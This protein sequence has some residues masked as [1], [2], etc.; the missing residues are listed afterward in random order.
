MARLTLIASPSPC[1][2]P[3]LAFDNIAVR[4]G[5]AAGETRYSVS[6]APFDN[7][8][9]TTLADQAPLETVRARVPI[10]SGVWSP[11][12]PAGIQYAVAAVAT[13]TPQFSHWATPVRVTIR[14][15]GAMID[16][17]GIERPTA[18]PARSTTATTP[19]S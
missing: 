6:W 18:F 13:L 5:L 15:R 11:P 17:V 7:R 14:N 8:T 4:L 10:P 12:D 1:P 16:V 2:A 19:A 3:A 9:A